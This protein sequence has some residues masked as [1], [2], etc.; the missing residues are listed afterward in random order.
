MWQELGVA[1]CLVLVREGILPFLSPRQWRSG[2]LQLTRL[3]DWQLRL[4]GLTS[5]LLGTIV[6]YW[7]H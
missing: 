2:L 1:L 3:S 5:M 6:L 4:M 7:L